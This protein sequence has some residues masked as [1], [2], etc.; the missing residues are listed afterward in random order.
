MIR[1]TKAQREQWKEKGYLVVEDAYEG[2][3][4]KRLQQ[5]F[6]RC[7]EEARPEWLEEVEAGTRPAGYFDI[8]NPLEK[9]SAF[10]DLADHPS[11]FGLLVDLLGEDLVFKGP[12][13]RTLPL[14]PVSY[15]GWHP[16]I[17]H[18]D[19]QH[20][21]VQIYV[22]DVPL[23]GGA[24]AYVPGSHKPDAGPYPVVHQLEHMPGHKVFAGKAGTAILFS[25]YGWHT[26]M[27]NKTQE[28]RKSIILGYGVWHE[29]KYDPK[30]HT[31][32]AAQLTTP[33]RRKLFCLER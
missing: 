31:A 25:T 13:V 30:R 2:E 29:D 20:I 16:D 10:V 17:P 23:D 3:D 15:I 1:A 22:D 8:P 6:G 19:P 5:A 12:Q 26:S 9:D 14:S 21:K 4:L 32:I 33:Q 27:I 11:Y 18:T 7:A 28:P 24:F